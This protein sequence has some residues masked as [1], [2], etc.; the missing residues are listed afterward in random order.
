MTNAYIIRTPH[1]ARFIGEIELIQFLV[2]ELVQLWI[3]MLP[4]LWDKISDTEKCSYYSGTLLFRPPW[5][6][7]LI[8]GVARLHV[9]TLWAMA[10]QKCFDFSGGQGFTSQKTFQRWPG[11][12]HHQ[13]CSTGIWIDRGIG[14]IFQRGSPRCIL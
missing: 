7:G 9:M 5:E 12:L 8:R 13:V 1:E 6:S 4:D 3:Q 14:R 10:P 2:A 11:V